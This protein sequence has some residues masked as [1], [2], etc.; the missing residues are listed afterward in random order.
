MAG[1][2]YNVYQTTRVGGQSDPL[3]GTN[4]IR[5]VEAAVLDFHTVFYTTLVPLEADRIYCPS[6]F[7]QA[8]TR[9]FAGLFISFTGGATLQALWNLTTGAVA[10][11]NTITAS[12]GTMLARGSQSYGGNWWRVWFAFRKIGA[13]PGVNIQM[14][15][16]GAAGV[17]TNYLGT[18]ASWTAYGMQ[19]STANWPGPVVTS[20]GAI[21]PPMRNTP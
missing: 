3:G 17:A 21:T 14:C 15:G 8:G 7:L 19:L 11:L 16:G 2:S 13:D 18:G 9:T 20:A 6:V 1:G 12:A 4:A 10:P 5:V